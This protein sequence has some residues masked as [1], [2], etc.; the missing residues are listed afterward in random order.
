MVRHSSGHT[1]LS[2][3]SHD[4]GHMC[5]LWKVMVCC[6]SGHTVFSVDSH[7]T[8]HTVLAVESYGTLLL[9]SHCVV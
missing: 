2:V 7:D 8:G 4:A 1:V 6:S 9:W 3:S 5:C